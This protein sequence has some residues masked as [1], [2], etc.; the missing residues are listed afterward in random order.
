MFSRDIDETL[1]HFHDPRLL[2]HPVL[3]TLAA[4]PGDEQAVRQAPTD[5][6]LLIN[7]KG[8]IRFANAAAERI[9]LAP[10]GSLKGRKFGFPLREG[11]SL[12]DVHSGGQ[13]MSTAVLH[14]AHL[15]RK[16]RTD[17]L[18]TLRLKA[19]ET[20]REAGRPAG[21]HA[22]RNELL[23]K[24]THHSPF[25]I[26]V[27]NLSGKVTVWSKAATQILGWSA[28]DMLGHSLPDTTAT[29]SDSLHELWQRTVQGEASAGDELFNQKRDDGRLVD[30]KVWSVPMRNAQGMPA[31]ALL[32]L[33]DV[34]RER[35]MQANLRHVVDH[36]ALTGLPHRQ[37]FR[38]QLHRTLR[39]RKKAGEQHLIVLAVGIDRFKSINKSLGREEG[40]FLLQQI[41][42][43]L[44]GALYETDLIARTGG[45]EFSVML[46]DTRHIRDASRVADK[47]LGCFAEPFELRGRSIYATASIGIAV[48]PVDGHTPKALMHAAEAAMERSKERGGNC[49]NFYARHMDEQALAQLYLEQE[50]HF[51]LERGQLYLDYQPQWNLKTGR[52]FGVEALLRWQHPQLGLV[53]PAT[54]I[55]LADST[56]LI[57][58]IGAWVLRE[59]SLQLRRWADAMPEQSLRMSVNVSPRQFESGTLED[60]VA[61]AIAMSGIAP[62]QLELEITESM[63]ARDVTAVALTL[64]NLRAQGVRV[65]IDDF[66]TGYSSLAYLADLPIDALKIDQSFVRQLESKPGCKAIIASVM[67]LARGLGLQV[68]AEGVETPAQLAYL[69]EVDCDEGQGYLMARPLPPAGVEALFGQPMPVQAPSGVGAVNVVNA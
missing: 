10:P 26:V 6:V 59:A 39:N 40:D 15:P 12:V 13:G 42:E 8:H 1:A 43:R 52:L 66:G 65:A 9:L 54:F 3:S 50:L 63:M 18:V 30:L 37:Q 11:F 51:A 16:R 38:K 55:P 2:G 57:G 27:V 24:L 36:D 21:E 22:S 20:S 28:H 32:I 41:V 44:S 33:S 29:G 62:E 61:E 46:R 48:A 49:S 14:C 4:W 45:D 64:K 60:D 69:R 68:I 5:G 19:G 17:Y 35:R 67:A 53:S 58:P 47:L 25:G 31:G 56:G 23:Q 7:A 34:T